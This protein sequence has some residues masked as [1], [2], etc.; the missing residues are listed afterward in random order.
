M[1]L[2]VYLFV[3]ACLFACTGVR[4]FACPFV[5]MF[6]C[7]FECLFNRLR[8]WIVCVFVCLF[9]CLTVVRSFACFRLSV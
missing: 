9:A 5:S 4:V 6:V 8:Y 3:C 1:C 7:V 2:P